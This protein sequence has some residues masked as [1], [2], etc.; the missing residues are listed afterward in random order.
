[1]RFNRPN[2]L[3]SVPAQVERVSP[4]QPGGG[5]DELHKTARLTSPDK[6]FRQAVPEVQICA[7]ILET[8]TT[9]STRKRTRVA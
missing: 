9:L 8:F 1:M 6:S 4:S 3:G 5:G 7:A 2:L